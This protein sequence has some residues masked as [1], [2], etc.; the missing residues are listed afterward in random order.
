MLLSGLG[1][2]AVFWLDVNR[3]HD[4]QLIAKVHQ[5]LALLDTKGVQISILSPEEAVEIAKKI[6]VKPVFK[7]V[8]VAARIPEL[9]QGHVDILAAS[10]THNKEREAQIDFSL[11]TFVAET[12]LLTR[13][14]E[15]ALYWPRVV[16][17]PAL[18]CRAD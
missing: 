5:G 4:A 13:A 7:Q 18:P 3:S 17:V 9:Q 2:V 12:R 8:A 1:V 11:T 10:L 14:G 6:G 16:E 15:R